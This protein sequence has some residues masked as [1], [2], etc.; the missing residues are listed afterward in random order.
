MCCKRKTD[1]RPGGILQGSAVIEK[2]KSI[3]MPSLEKGFED[4]IK[5]APFA[6]LL[7]FYS[8]AAVH[9]Q[10]EVILWVYCMSSMQNFLILLWVIRLQH[11]QMTTQGPEV[12]SRHSC[13]HV[14]FC[15]FYQP[16]LIFIYSEHFKWAPSSVEQEWPDH[17]HIPVV[18]GI[19]TWKL[20]H[21]MPWNT[22]FLTQKFQ[23]LWR[24]TDR[25]LNTK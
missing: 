17:I 9:N 13:I 14:L 21:I 18:T 6:S 25:T 12:E 16:C 5:W 1:L 23:Q 2:V 19:H 3:E 7:P 4:Q 11:N 8:Y 22:V 20:S 24:H 15:F 10:S